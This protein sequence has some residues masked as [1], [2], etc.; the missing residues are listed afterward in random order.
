MTSERRA[1]AAPERIETERLLM[2]RPR[3]SDADSIFARYASDPEVTRF[4]AF[5]RHRSLEDTRAFLEWSEAEWGRWPAGPYLIEAREG[6]TL[7]GSTGFAFETPRRA[8]TG[9]VL[10]RDAWGLGYATEA[11]GAVVAAARPLGVRRLYALCHPDHEASAHVLEKCGF[12][13]E[14]IL[15]RHSVFPNLAPDEPGDALCYAIVFD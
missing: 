8:A 13:R 14:A 1:T 9:Y 2:R 5:P 7:L 10:A 11:L 6:G 3:L 15:R 4:M 12:V